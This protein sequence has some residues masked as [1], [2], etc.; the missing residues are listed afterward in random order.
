MSRRTQLE[1]YLR[2]RENISSKTPR[3]EPKPRRRTHGAVWPMLLTA[4]KCPKWASPA[5]LSEPGAFSIT[6]AADTLS[7]TREE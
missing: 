3:A 5:Y 6:I 4:S 2:V 7:Q 1:R